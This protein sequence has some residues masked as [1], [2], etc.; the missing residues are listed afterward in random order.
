MQQRI[1]KGHN[2]AAEKIKQRLKIIKEEHT[3]GT[4][5]VTV[6]ALSSTDEDNSPRTKTLSTKCTTHK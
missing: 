5:E 4:K 6:D 2:G 1:G 3:I